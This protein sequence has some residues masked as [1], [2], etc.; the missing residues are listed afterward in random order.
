MKLAKVLIDELEKGKSLEDVQFLAND[1]RKEEKAK[2]T[3]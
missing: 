2:F 1:M 3:A